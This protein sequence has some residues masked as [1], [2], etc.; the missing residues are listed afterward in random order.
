MLNNNTYFICAIFVIHHVLNTG[1]KN[2][3]EDIVLTLKKFKP[4]EKIYKYGKEAI[5]R[6]YTLL[7][8]LK[9]NL[10]YNLL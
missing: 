3:Y 2:G 4:N 5:K 9:E 10:M 6:L 8:R 7:K 1:N